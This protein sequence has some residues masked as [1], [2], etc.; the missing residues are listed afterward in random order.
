MATTPL[1]RMS[2]E[3]T[4][5]I[6]TVLEQ[7]GVSTHTDL[8]RRVDDEYGWQ[9]R[10]QT[11][12]YLVEHGHVA[13]IQGFGGTLY[14]LLAQ[15]NGYDWTNADWLK[16]RI[17]ADYLVT[18]CSNHPAQHLIRA[19]AEYMRAEHD[20]QRESHAWRDGLRDPERL[21]ELDHQESEQIEDIYPA[22]TGP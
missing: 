19:I 18:D 12:G 11:L 6:L 4:K 8:A 3:R 10:P 15:W 17:G 9:L 16:L 22:N 20:L 21:A 14:Y 2:D 7:L 5:R 13:V 1:K